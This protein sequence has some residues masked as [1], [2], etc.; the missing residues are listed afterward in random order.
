MS[1]PALQ[2]KLFLEGSRI[3]HHFVCTN[4][5]KNVQKCTHIFGVDVQQRTTLRTG[6]T[7]RAGARYENDI[8]FRNQKIGTRNIKFDLYIVESAAAPVNRARSNEIL[9][10]L[11]EMNAITVEQLL[12]QGDF[13]FAD[14][15]LQ[16]IKIQREQLQQCQM[17]E[18]ISPE[19]AQQ[20]QQG[21][22]MQ[23]AQRAQEMLQ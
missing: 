10:K 7:I 18:G 3:W 14:E 12:E 22:D 8:E 9:M 4:E 16:S 6:S 15:L 20:A 2:P 11:F 13:P 19:L 1:N 21:A 23:A 5:H 17:P